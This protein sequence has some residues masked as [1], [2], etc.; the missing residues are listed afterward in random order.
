MAYATS[1][2]LFL[3]DKVG[4][5]GTTNNCLFRAFLKTNITTC[6]QIRIDYIKPEII[7]NTCPAISFED[8][9]FKFLPEKLQGTQNG[10]GSGFS[11]TTK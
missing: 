6:A 11:Q 10:V 8:M 4:R 1:G 2:A 9:L 7:A 5:F 3:Y